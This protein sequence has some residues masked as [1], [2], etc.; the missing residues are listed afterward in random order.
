[1]SSDVTRRVAWSSIMK[2]MN[3]VREHDDRLTQKI[4]D[5]MMQKLKIFHQRVNARMQIL[6]AKL[7]NEDRN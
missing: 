1:V 3:G 5:S 7:P 6:F 2:M 4:C